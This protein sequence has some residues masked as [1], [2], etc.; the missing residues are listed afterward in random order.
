MAEVKCGTCWDYVGY[1][2]G[3]LLELG[4]KPKAWFI[5]IDDG[6]NVPSH[7]FITVDHGDKTYLFETAYKKHRGLWVGDEKRIISEEFKWLA[8]EYGYTIG[9][10]PTLATEYDPMESKWYDIGVER[11][12]ENIEPRLKRFGVNRADTALDS[13]DG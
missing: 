11:L 5:C 12:M 13:Y 9:E 2:Y 8:E 1:G 3:Q 6:H 7:T 4:L 10:H